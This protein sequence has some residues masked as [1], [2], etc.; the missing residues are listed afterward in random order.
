MIQTPY[1]LE[2]E[3]GMSYYATDAPGIGGVLRVF[4]ED[5]VVE[6]IPRFQAGEGPY[7]ICNL[8]KTNWETQRA[9]KEIARKLRISHRRISWAG[10]KD[11]RAQTSQYIS[12]YRVDPAEIASIQLK[13]ITLRV[14]GQSQT[15]LS[16]GDLEGNRFAITI[17]ECNPE[18]LE[19]RVNRGVDHARTG[20][21]NYFGIQRFGALRPVTHRIGELM[22]R[23]DFRA[24]VDT[25]IG[26]TCATEPEEIQYARTLYAESGDVR[27]A[28]GLFPLHLRYERAMLHYL[29]EHPGDMQG[30]LLSLPPKL[31]SMFVSA[32]QSY[33]FNL[34]LS[35]RMDE[36]FSLVDPAVGDTLL[37][38]GG[39][40]DIATDKN[41]QTARVHIRRG[42]CVIAQFMP[43]SVPFVP[44]GPID[45]YVK[46]CMESHSIDASGFKAVSDLLGVRFE[47]AFRPVIVRTD[48]ESAIENQIVRL[49]FSLQPG[50][51]ATTICRE[52]MKADPLKMV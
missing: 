36:G 35:K 15:G 46:E 40:T 26:W 49:R 50:Q 9:I 45:A 20:F 28:L 19:G 13:D 25:Y 21:P 43:G 27:E 6:E 24:A 23:G 2:K 39:K 51:Y 18:D 52:F 38:E 33:L 42:R 4:P 30:A 34:A 14:V 41:L 10:T 16:L 5:F 17:R 22:L 8:I 32:Y 29:V 3:L 11:K 12:L 37:F 7:L 1:P 44:I 48:I 31:I 47:G